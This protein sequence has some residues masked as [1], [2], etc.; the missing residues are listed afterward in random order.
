M[1]MQDG[2]QSTRSAS[3]AALK[4]KVAE[5]LAKRRAIVAAALRPEPRYDEVFARGVAWLDS[6][7]EVDVC[8]QTEKDRS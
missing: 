8:C 4:A 2:M 1:S 5:R 6:D 3:I 7:G